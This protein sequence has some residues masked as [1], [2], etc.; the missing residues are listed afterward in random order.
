[1]PDSNKPQ[2]SLLDVISGNKPVQLEVS[3]DTQSL[4]WL[5]VTVF[6]AVCAAVFISKKM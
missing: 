3:I 4:I 5:G 2:G 1:M 6:V